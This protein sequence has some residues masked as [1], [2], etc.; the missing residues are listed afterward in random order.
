MLAEPIITKIGNRHQIISFEVQSDARSYLANLIAKELQAA[1][2]SRGQA[3]WLAAGGGTPKPLYEAL[4]K[5]EL[6][7][8]KIKL[9]V[10]DERFVPLSSP[11]SNE[12]M[13]RQI[14]SHGGANAQ[15]IIGLVGDCADTIISAKSAEKQLL[16]LG[17]GS[18]PKVDFAL[19]GMGPDGHYASIFPRHP[20]NA[21][22]YQTEDLVMPIAP[23]NIAELE[24]KIA[25]LTLTPRA[26]NQCRKVV[27]Y[28]S[29]Q[30]KLDVLT[31]MANQ[32]DPFI[33]PIGAYLAQA[34]ATISF[35][36]AK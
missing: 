32:T 15:E 10:L 31:A 18:P 17:N 12:A 9:I 20:T 21:T 22:I 13:L 36:W 25:R 6:Q 4:A 5:L 29:G 19:M 33:S 30:E 28:I 3:I 2:N 16:E 35:V 23:L 24:P 27:F 1:I 8:P 7:W 26:I 14:F 34:P 11:F